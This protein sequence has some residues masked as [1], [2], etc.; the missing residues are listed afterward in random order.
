MP[1]DSIL[2]SGLRTVARDFGSSQ[3]LSQASQSI[4]WPASSPPQHQPAKPLSSREARMKAIEEGIRAG[5][6]EASTPAAPLAPS[7]LN[8]RYS[9]DET[10]RPVKKARTLP[11][12]FQDAAHKIGRSTFDQRK[13]TSKT[14]ASS[15]NDLSAFKATTSKV[16]YSATET[17]FPDAFLS[18]EQKGVLKLAEK[19]TS[20]FYT[21]SAGG[22]F[23]YIVFLHNLTFIFPRNGK[24]SFTTSNY[25]RIEENT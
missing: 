23:S 25:K 21:G 15:V 4:P 16:V 22:Q 8:K 12:S 18:A 3:E 20:L 13:P 19:G 9:P 14:S 1:K 11:S 5:L 2:R 17:D 7:S 6:K 24:I 10:T